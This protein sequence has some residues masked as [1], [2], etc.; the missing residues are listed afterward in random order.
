MQLRLRIDCLQSILAASRLSQNHWAIRLGLSRGHWSEIV[1]GKHPC[2]SARTRQRMLEVFEVPLDE[3]FEVV[4]GPHGGEETA[5][6]AALRERY[7]I[8]SE[9]AHGSRR[10]RT[11][12]SWAAWRPCSGR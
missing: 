2:P 9:L 11:R 7:L 10:T 12:A 6:R 5:F 1:N 8:H 3:L 4:P